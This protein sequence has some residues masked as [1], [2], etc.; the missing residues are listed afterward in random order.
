MTCI[1]AR[2]TLAGIL[3]LLVAQAASVSAGSP[4][5]CD[6]RVFVFG[7]QGNPGYCRVQHQCGKKYNTALRHARA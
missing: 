4:V 5:G 1:R 2:S 7:G 6:G 3:V